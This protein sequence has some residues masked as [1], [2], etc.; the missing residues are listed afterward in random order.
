MLVQ[1]LL[2]VTSD[3]FFVTILA[4][5]LAGILGYCD[6]QDRSTTLIDIRVVDSEGY[7]QLPYLASALER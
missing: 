5:G 4:V 7:C 3:H 1:F 6:H 2:A